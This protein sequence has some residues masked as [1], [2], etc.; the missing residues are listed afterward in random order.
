LSAGTSPSIVQPNAVDSPPSNVGR[1]SAGSACSNATMPRTSSSICA[2]VRRTFLRLWVSDTESGIV[3]L[4]ALACT[5]AS[6]PLRFGTSTA[7]LSPGIDRACATSSAVSASCGRSFAGTKLP[8]SISRTPAA[9]SAVTHAF[10]A[11]SGMIG[12]MLCSPS[13][14]PTSLT[15]TSIAMRRLRRI[16]CS[17]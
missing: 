14:G 3:I 10:F 2:C 5:A 7:T 6:A 16:H 8:T 4:W 15:S 11:S 13:R 12:R 17:T 9:A 1:S